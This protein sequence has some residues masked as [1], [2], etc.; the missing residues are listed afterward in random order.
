MIATLIGPSGSD[1]RMFTLVA[2]TVLLMPAGS[3]A[4]KF[5]FSDLSLS[6]TLVLGSLGTALL[7][8]LCVILYGCSTLVINSLRDGATS[9]HNADTI[10]L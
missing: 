8:S 1:R 7:V 3:L 9:P 2:L 5:A 4:A 6:E 10:T